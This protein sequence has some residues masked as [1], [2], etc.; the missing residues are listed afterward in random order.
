[1]AALLACQPNDIEYAYINDELKDEVVFEVLV[2]REY[3]YATITKANLM[4]QLEM[5]NDLVEIEER[6]KRGHPTY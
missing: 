5:F 2:G 6:I 3:V 4:W 1:M